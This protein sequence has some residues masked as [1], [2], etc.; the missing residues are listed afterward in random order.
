MLFSKTSALFVR[1]Q[2]QPHLFTALKSF[3]RMI[4]QIWQHKRFIIKPAL[5]KNI[6][7]ENAPSPACDVRSR[8]YAFFQMVDYLPFWLA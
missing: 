4:R 1:S 5:P 6:I 7:R 2:L 8:T 3:S